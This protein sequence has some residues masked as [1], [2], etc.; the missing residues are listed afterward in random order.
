M[1]SLSGNTEKVPRGSFGH[2]RRSSDIKW[3]H[4][5]CSFFFLL[6]FY[7][8]LPLLSL[9]VNFGD[10]RAQTWL[11][12]PPSS[13]EVYLRTLTFSLHTKCTDRQ[14][15][16][17]TPGSLAKQWRKIEPRPLLYVYSYIQIK[18]FQLVEKNTF[19]VPSV[20]SFSVCTAIT[21]SVYPSSQVLHNQ[22]SE[23]KLSLCSSQ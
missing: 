6:F 19:L 21:L 10:L 7:S 18:S 11:P 4:L 2:L 20:D 5:N 17:C 15:G 14:V 3:L 8:P 23:Q 22:T 13:L 9:S 1:H 12:C 16:L